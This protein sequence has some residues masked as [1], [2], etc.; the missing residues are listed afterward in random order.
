MMQYALVFLAGVLLD[1][2]W[3]G[4]AR[5]VQEKNAAKAVG[6]SMAMG[7][8]SVLAIGAAVTS[9]LLAVPYILGLGAGTLIGLKYL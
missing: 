3:V 2:L 6:C 9:P 8:C 4:Y 5:G 1:V 7:L